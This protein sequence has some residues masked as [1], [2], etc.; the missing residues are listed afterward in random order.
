MQ[1]WGG[2]MKLMNLALANIR[3]SKS[4]TISLFIFILV[5]ALLLNI[6][7][8]VITQVSA[9]F[10]SKVEQL[11]DPHA[12]LM[13]DKTG[14]NSTYEQFIKSYPGINETETEDIIIMNIAK[15]N[16]GDSELAS[17]AAIFN[18]DQD[19]SIGAIKLIEKL[20]TSSTR[21]IYIPYS[22]KT[23]GGYQLGDN[24]TITYQEKDYHYRIAGFFETTIM[25]TTS[26]GIM[27]FMLPEIPYE[28]PDQDLSYSMVNIPSIPRSKIEIKNVKLKM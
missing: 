23:N 6:G 17:N 3:K 2:N 13:M 16:F 7:V 28:F 22:F 27:K 4:A 1:K 9:F 21:D 14:Y 25:G 5:A 8:M 10:D 11:K 15:Y 24:F 18:A 26:M 19:R 12:I 20:D